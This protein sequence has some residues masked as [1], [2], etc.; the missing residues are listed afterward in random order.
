MSC[1]STMNHPLGANHH[2]V[3]MKFSALLCLALVSSATAFGVVRPTA[4]VSRTVALAAAVELEPEP[5]GGEELSASVSIANTRV[6]KMEAVKSDEGEAFN[7]WMTSEVDGAL[8][9]EIR[10]QILKDASK[11]ANFPGFRKVRVMSGRSL[12]DSTHT[13]DRVKF[14]RTRSL[15]LPCSRCKKPS[16]KRCRPPSTP[17]VSKRWRAAMEK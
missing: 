10:T 5:E 12:V 8:I 11:K 15:K 1:F 3:T 16:S 2:S 14:L 17:T 7:F 4:G 13:L 6:K 9:K